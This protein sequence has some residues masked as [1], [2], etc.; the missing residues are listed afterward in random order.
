MNDGSQSHKP[1]HSA[2]ILSRVYRRPV[3]GAIRKI[4]GLLGSLGVEACLDQNTA[5]GFNI[6]EIRA[7]SRSEMRTKDL[8]IVV[9]GDG[10]LL[11]AARTLVD[12]RVP[13]LGVNA[14]H[15]GLLTDLSPEGL[16]DSLKE[17][18]AGRYSVEQRTML[19]LQVFR[20]DEDGAGELVAQSL[21][22]NETVIH[23]GMMA[24]MM[25]FKVFI[26]GRYMYALRG[27]GIIVNTPTG[28]TAYSL[29][30]GG[31]II[32]P[33]LDVLALVPMF[34]QSLNCSPIIIPG[35]S[36]VRIDF[37]GPQGEVPELVAINCDGQVTMRADTKCTVSIRQHRVMLK[38]IHPEGYDYYSLL[39]QKLGW[40][41]SLV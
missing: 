27:D 9:G 37:E 26:D 12:L 36:A 2:V 7:V 3:S 20:E 41:Q 16:N 10:S 11:G 32:E 35:K 21:A 39:R 29:S 6:H 17:V 15:L 28:S 24:H 18:V 1:I 14:G 40:G 30:A 23:S 4:A 22:T 34:P 5:V 8:F 13:M 19:D 25:T 33:H 31:S 38:L